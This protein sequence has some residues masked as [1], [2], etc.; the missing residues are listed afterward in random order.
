MYYKWLTVKQTKLD[1]SLEYG[2]RT[3]GLTLQPVSTLLGMSTCPA[4]TGECIKHC[5]VS[6]GRN[7]LDH[8]VQARA[9][10]MRELNE[11]FPQAIADIMLEIELFQ[12][13]SKRI[14]LKP[15]VR[16]NVTSDL[17]WESLAPQVFKRFPELQFYDYTKRIDRI[18]PFDNRLPKNYHLTYSHNANSNSADCIRL[19]TY[20]FNIAM[21][22]RDTM[23]RSVELAGSVFDCIDGDKHDLRFLDPEGII[24][25]L[26]YKQAFN[27]R[28]GKALAKPK[29]LCIV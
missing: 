12:A 1:K 27:R 29:T 4:A 17:A 20:G 28:T 2:Y 3:A 15:C 21:I 16:L 19:L 11:N 6:C 22:Y 10:R 8:A 18:K 7:R 9:R 23:P 24:V 26:K 5:L 13:E 25:A 14:G